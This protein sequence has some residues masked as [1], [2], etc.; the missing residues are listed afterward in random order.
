M[1]TKTFKEL[2][3]FRVGGSIK[4][5]KEVSTN[6]DILDAISFA[7]KNSLDIFIIG[8]GS[9]I[10][11]SDEDF[12][13]LVIKYVG[14]DIKI[15]GETIT[16]Q[17]GVVWDDLV[18]VAIENDLQGME[19]LSGIPGSVGAAPIQNIG[20]Y[21]QE[22]KDT[23]FSLTAYD[24]NE[25]KFVTFNNNDCKFAYRESIFKQKDYWQRY[26]I[27][28]VKFKL[29]KNGLPTIKYDSLANYLTENSITDPSLSEVRE[30]VLKIRTTKFES[31]KDIGNAGSFFK[32]PIIEEIDADRLL[33]KYPDIPLRKLS[34]GKYKTFA[35]WFI[36][37]LGWKGKAFKSASVSKNHALV[38]IN[39]DGK[40]KA[41][42]LMELS[43]EIIRDV[44]EN[45]GIEL[46][47]EVQFINFN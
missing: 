8:G 1:G 18:R 24:F 34:D 11:V 37:K 29:K 26:L 22:L 16:A 32:N 30:A 41:S 36:E 46:H 23:F 17:A 6:E 42:D 20:A 10:L 31:P 21:G 14:S 5:Y 43:N 4:E 13:G 25:D 28:E 47:P 12:N 3:T 39:P 19:S 40:A 27:T 44:N 45:F 9:D 15:D 35:G 2:T 38:L 7:K 33:E